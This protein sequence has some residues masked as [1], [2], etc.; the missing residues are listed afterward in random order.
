MKRT[1]NTKFPN[2]V[3]LFKF[4]NKVLIH[5]R[6]DK[7]RDQEIGNI[8]DYNP[9]DCSHWKRGDKNVR[10]VFAL[11]KLSEALNVEIQLIYDIVNGLIGCDEAYF[12]YLENLVM[13]DANKN[14]K[15]IK[16]TKEVEECRSRI[17]SF[18][19]Q[20]LQ[21]TNLQTP[22]LYLPEIFRNFSFVST[23]SIDMIDKLSRILRVKPGQYAVHIRKGDLKPQ[24]RWSALKDLS[25]IL[26]EAERARYPEL[27]VL[28]PELAAYEQLLFVANLLVPKNLLAQELSKLDSK[29]NIVHEL[30]TVFWAPKSIICMQLSEALKDT[31][32]KQGLMN[33]RNRVV[34]DVAE[35]SGVAT[36]NNDTSRVAS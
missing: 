15:D 16:F 7:V 25:R 36:K 2:S 19:S 32:P 31:T 18:T 21:Q 30:A 3:Q 8:L 34:G 14:L 35:V 22:P 6:G 27:G 4:C 24:T 1:G 10:S 9:S 26:F 23:Q 13:K 29:K 28:N 12:E 5:Q 17:S 20:L 11:S 33:Y